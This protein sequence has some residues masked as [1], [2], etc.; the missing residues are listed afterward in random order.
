MAHHPVT[1]EAA[2]TNVSGPIFVLNEHDANILQGHFTRAPGVFM[3]WAGHTHRA[4]RTSP[5]AAQRVGLAETA[6]NGGYPGGYTLLHLYTGGYMMN[7][8]RIGTEETLRWSARSRWAGLGI[9]PDYALGLT[10][11]RNYVVRRDLSG[12]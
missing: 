9:N 8:H 2:W 1:R 6:S 11:H 5:D 7:F 3:M 12:I 4:R 10:D